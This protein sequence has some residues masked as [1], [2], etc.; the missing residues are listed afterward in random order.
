VP[1]LRGTTIPVAVIDGIS[2]IAPAAIPS[3][4][5]CPDK[6]TPPPVTAE[7]PAA[8]LKRVAGRIAVAE[9]G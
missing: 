4:G 5:L 3:C 1:A 2:V 8:E 7:A 6:L 9:R